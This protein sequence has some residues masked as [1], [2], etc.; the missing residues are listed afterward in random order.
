MRAFIACHSEILW[1]MRPAPALMRG[2]SGGTT[3]DGSN[4]FAVDDDR[5]LNWGA[6]N[7]GSWFGRFAVYYL[8]PLV[9]ELIHGA[10]LG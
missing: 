2:S 6:E 1:N 7:P 4:V 5:A 3:R 8:D 9:N 10:V